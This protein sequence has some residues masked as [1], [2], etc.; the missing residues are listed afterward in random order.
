MATNSGSTTMPPAKL[1]PFSTGS[2]N[3]MWKPATRP[4][5]SGKPMIKASPVQKVGNCCPVQLLAA[6]RPAPHEEG[7]DDADDQGDRQDPETRAGESGPACRGR[8]C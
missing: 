1:K 6:M 5:S 2:E 8:G 3:V 7:R 4:I